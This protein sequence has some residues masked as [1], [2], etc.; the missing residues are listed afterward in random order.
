MKVQDFSA[1]R[2]AAADQIL[3]TQILFTH[4]HASA[5]PLMHPS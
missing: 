5:F 2:R 1:I 3:F 4:P